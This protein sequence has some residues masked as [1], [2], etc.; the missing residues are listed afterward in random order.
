M[1]IRYVAIGD[2]FTEG[3]GD[4]YPD[5]TPRGWADR[6][7]EQIAALRSEPVY[8]ANLAIRG[9]C[10]EPIVTEQLEAALALEPTTIASATGATGPPI[11]STSTLPGTPESP[12]WRSARSVSATQ[13]SSPTR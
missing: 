11:A 7:A 4:E 12:R 6:L 1:A 13:K 2:S 5:G 9:R 8:Y 10:L 3:V